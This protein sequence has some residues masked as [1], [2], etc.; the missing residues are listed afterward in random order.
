MVVGSLAYSVNMPDADS[1]PYPKNPKP[2]ILVFMNHWN[3]MLLNEEQYI[4]KMI[5]VSFIR[6][7][8]K[9]GSEMGIEVM[10]RV[11]SD[12]LTLEEAYDEMVREE[13]GEDALESRWLRRIMK[14][15]FG[16]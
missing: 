11:V 5:L 9:E 15:Y 1:K 12:E 3:R 14:R 16:M 6:G 4:H 13:L 7:E 2:S 10:N 8:F